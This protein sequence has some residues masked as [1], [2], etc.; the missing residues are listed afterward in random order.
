VD[1]RSFFGWFTRT[2]RKDILDQQVKKLPIVKGDRRQ[3]RN[4]ELDIIASDH[5]DRIRDWYAG[6]G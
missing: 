3:W 1:L 2:R 6:I 5:G 4:A